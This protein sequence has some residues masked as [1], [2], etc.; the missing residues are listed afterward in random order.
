M[1]CSMPGFPVFHYLWACS[2]S[3]PFTQWYHPTISS[4]LTSFSSCPQSFPAAGSF[5]MSW[6]FSS[7]KVLELQPQHFSHSNEYTGLISSRIDW[8]DLLCRA[9]DSQES[10][11]APQ[12]SCQFFD[13]Q[14]SLWPNSHIYPWLL[15]KP[16]K[17]KSRYMVDIDRENKKDHFSLECS[18]GT[19]TLRYTII[20]HT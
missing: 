17:Q 14:P 16:K 4:S 5:P 1:D 15:E 20:V 6:L 13:I 11:P 18:W 12:F 8:F 2:N 7:A 19:K 10:S 9:G 3:C